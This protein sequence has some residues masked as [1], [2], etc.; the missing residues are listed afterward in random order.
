[1]GKQILEDRSRPVFF[2][3]RQYLGALEA[4][5]VAGSEGL[6]GP[7]IEAVRAAPYLVSLGMIGLVWWAA[8]SLFGRPAAVVATA[9]MALPSPYL[10]APYSVL[11]AFTR[12]ARLTTELVERARAR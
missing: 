5:L 11:H 6:F 1:M 2:Q 7:T 3:G 4:Y 8:R 9:V 10:V 12:R